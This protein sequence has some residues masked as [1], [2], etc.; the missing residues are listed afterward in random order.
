MKE[1]ERSHGTCMAC[2]EIGEIF[3][4]NGEKKWYCKECYNEI[5]HGKIPNVTYSRPG[6]PSQSHRSDS[7]NSG[8]DPSWHNTMRLLEERG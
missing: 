8:D 5:Y 6:A 3:R 1:R 2:S 4:K 7:W